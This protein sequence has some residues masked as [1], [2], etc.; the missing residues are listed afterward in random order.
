MGAHDIDARTAARAARIAFP[1]AAIG[2]PLAMLTGSVLVEVATVFAY[3]TGAVMLHH[4]KG[5][6]VL[7]A[8]A[9]IALG[10]ALVS[11]AGSIDPW[12]TVLACVFSLSSLAAY[13]SA[14]RIIRSGEIQGGRIDGVAAL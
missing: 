11:T 6:R 4:A 14:S 2:L 7:D 12:Q 13:L 3:V 10:A 8:V 9:G 5:G 1:C